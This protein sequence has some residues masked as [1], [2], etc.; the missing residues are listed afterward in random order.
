MQTM[1]VVSLICRGRRGSCSWHLGCLTFSLK[2]MEDGHVVVGKYS[3][4]G[5]NLM[6]VMRLISNGN[7]KGGVSWVRG[8]G[9]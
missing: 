7:Y 4:S 3:D 5:A 1:G 9:R 8:G 2:K 6:M